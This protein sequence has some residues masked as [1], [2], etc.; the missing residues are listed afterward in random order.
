[1]SRVRSR[2]QAPRLIPPAGKPTSLSS[3]TSVRNDASPSLAELALKERRMDRRFEGRR[4]S[5]ALGALACAVLLA[6][7]GGALGVAALLAASAPSF[8]AARNYATGRTP[9]SIAIGDLN[10]DGK[11]DLATANYAANTVSVLVKRRASARCR[12]SSDRRCRPRGARSCGPIAASGRSAGPTRG[13]R[14]AA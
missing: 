6:C 12:K 2:G 9:V 13:P 4:R 14:G 3:F 10:G 5:V 7:I 8:A 11:P 1:M